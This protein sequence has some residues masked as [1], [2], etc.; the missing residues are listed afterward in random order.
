MDSD[1]AT[2]NYAEHNIDLFKL[3]MDLAALSELAIGKVV[4]IIMRYE[5]HLISDPDEF[6]INLVQ[7]K[8]AT[9]RAINYIIQTYVEEKK[10]RKKRQRQRAEQVTATTE[11]STKYTNKENSSDFSAGNIANIIVLDSSDSSSDVV[12][13][14]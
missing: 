9:V 1:E 11:N 2:D 12:C 8:Q 5:P 10:R 7:L 6:S 3:K 4:N 14:S 13:L